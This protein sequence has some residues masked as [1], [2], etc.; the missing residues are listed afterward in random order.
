MSKFGLFNIQS[1]EQQFQSLTIF[2]FQA[3]FPDDRACL[4]YLSE[5]KW[6]DGYICPKCGNT[7]YCGGDREFSRQCTKCRY[8]CSPTSGTLFHKVK[9]PLLKAF[10]IV[11]YV[12]TN[13]KGISSTELSRKLGL[14][15][16][17][18]WLFKQKVMHGM[19]SSGKYKITGKAEVDETVVGGQ[20]EGVR[21][22]KNDKKKLVVFAIERMGKGVSRV[23]G[24]VI[25]KSS[26]KEL[27][28]FMKDTIEPDAQIKTDQWTGYKPLK[29][30]FAN[31]YQVPSGKKGGNFPDLHRVIMGFKG[32]L[33]G[34]HHQVENLQGYIDEYCYRFNRS[35]MKE[36][37]FDN[38]L[39][40]MVKADP[41]P[42]KIYCLNA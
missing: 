23:Y 8:I 33:R 15:Q 24:R 28:S 17:T 35:N 26:A 16:K 18:C 13:R 20:E 21:G 40:R 29:K 9:F 14:R 37:I 36:G 3:K 27:G 5:L 25:G 34:M 10:Y 6:A 2:D 4:S 31:L 32:W 42:Y 30:D 22:R 11:Y 38:L 41:L 12:S 19:K 1:M 7:K 39:A